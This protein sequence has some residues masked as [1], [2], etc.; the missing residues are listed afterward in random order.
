MN[1]NWFKI[2]TLP[3]EIGIVGYE[4][5]VA[6]VTWRGKTVAGAVDF[7]QTF[8]N[9]HTLL[10]ATS[11]DKW[12][13]DL[14]YVAPKNNAEIFVEYYEA[15]YDKVRAEVDRWFAP[16]NDG[17]DTHNGCVAHTVSALHLSGVPAPDY[18]SLSAINVQAFL[19][20]VLKNGWQ[21]ITD[22]SALLPGDVCTSGATLD[23]LDHVYTFV[24]YKTDTCAYVLHNQAW[25][26]SER[27]LTGGPCG[28]W[29]YAV[30]ML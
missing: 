24:K 8:G 16:I 21:K 15:N 12:P 2:Y 25:G 6:K 5:S 11:G 23:T 4:D 29:K 27:N 26:L 18:S 14:T 22:M 30:R 1:I 20:W 13:G 10:P 9:A 3:Q 28:E 7:M 17:S 19:A